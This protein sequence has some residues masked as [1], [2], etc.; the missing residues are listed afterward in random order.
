MP[1]FLCWTYKP[2]NTDL[3]GG[4]ISLQ[5]YLRW[6]AI[7]RIYLDNFEHIRT[8]VL[9]RN[10]DALMGLKYGADDFDLP[11]EDEVTQ[12]AGAT[13]SHDFQAILDTARGLGMDAVQ[14]PPWPVPVA[15]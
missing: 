4:E 8:S 10:A 14:R 1:S 7:S 2:W 11:T 9:T 6:L 13:I 12:K 5:A 3:G 15:N